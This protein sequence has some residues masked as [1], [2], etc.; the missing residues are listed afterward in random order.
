[1][2]IICF[3]VQ[4]IKFPDFKN[5]LIKLWLLLTDLAKH[6]ATEVEIELRGSEKIIKE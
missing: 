1:M 6:A 3:L 5:L 2:F 4:I